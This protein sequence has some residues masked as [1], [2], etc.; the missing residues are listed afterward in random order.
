MVYIYLFQITIERV[1]GK[2]LTENDRYYPLKVKFSENNTKEF[3]IP[4]D[5]KVRV[6]IDVPEKQNM[7]MRMDVRHF[8]DIRD[9]ETKFDK[10][11][12]LHRTV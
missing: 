10:I 11:Y 5:G 4:A 6:H 3:D 2:P 9:N 7:N 8:D 1:D 12:F